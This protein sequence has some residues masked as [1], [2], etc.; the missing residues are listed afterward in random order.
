MNSNDISV[1]RIETDE[2]LTHT[3]HYSLGS[4]RGNQGDGHIWIVEKDDLPEF[5]LRVIER[6]TKSLDDLIADSLK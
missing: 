4:A 5:R 6:F 2:F 3:L 1:V